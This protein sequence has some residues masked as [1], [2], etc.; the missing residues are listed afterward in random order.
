MIAEKIHRIKGWLFSSNSYIIGDLDLSTRGESKNEIAV[1]DP[2]YGLHL[3]GLKNENVKV[4]LTHIHPDHSVGLGTII[5]KRPE[6][7]AHPVLVSVL[8]KFLPN[9]LEA[10]DGDLIRV[11]DLTLMVIHTPGHSIDGICLY[12]PVQKILFS[13][14]TVYKSR[15]MGRASPLTGDRDMLL[16]SMQKIREMDVRTLLRGHGE[17]VLNGNQYIQEV[18]DSLKSRKS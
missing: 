1:I 13:G 4:I 6:I 17:P 5:F 10:N 16:K 15:I 12:E 7:Y 18:Y 9:V 11:D 3:L 14:D 2:G 8:R